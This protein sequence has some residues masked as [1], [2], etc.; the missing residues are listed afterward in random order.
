M[1]EILIMI[2]EFFN[3]KSLRSK[4][5]LIGGLPLIM[6]LTLCL[7]NLNFAEK[8]TNIVGNFAL[9]YSGYLW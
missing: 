9:S 2:K 8:I 1:K 7:I 3:D 5:F 4:S 6:F